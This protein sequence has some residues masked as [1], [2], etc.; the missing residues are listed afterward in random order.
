[1]ATYI[2]EDGNVYYENEPE[3]K[4]ALFPNLKRIVIDTT[5]SNSGEAADAKSVGDAISALSESITGEITEIDGKLASEKFTL[6]PNIT[7]AT[8]SICVGIHD[9]SVNTV[10]LFFTARAE[11]TF[12]TTDVLFVVPEDYRPA[13]DAYGVCVYFGSGVGGAYYFTLKNNG[14]VVQGVGNTLNQLLGYIEYQLPVV[15]PP[16]ESENDDVTP[17]DD[18]EN[19]G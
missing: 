7:M 14:N 6:T 16:D 4:R 12:S 13:E 2:T 1:M 8:G 17:P 3:E 10:R 5:L 19:E 18:N 9:K 15:T 11:S